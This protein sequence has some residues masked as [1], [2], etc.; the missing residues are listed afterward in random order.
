MKE[1]IDS[2]LNQTYSNWEL[3]SL[4]DCSTD[5]SPIIAE[6]YVKADSRVHYYRNEK[7]LQLP[8]NLNR[9]FSL[10]KG[11]YLTWTSDDNRYRPEALQKMADVLDKNPD[12][13]FV[14]ASSRIIDG[15][16]KEIEYIMVSP[17][18][19]DRIVGV[20][21][22]GACFLYTRLAYNTVGEYDADLKY[23]ED[24]DYWQ[25]ICMK[26][27]AIGISEILYDYR[28]HDKALTSTMS[29]EIF[30][31]NLEKMLL[32]NRPGFGKLS[33]HQNYLYYKSLSGCRNDMTANPYKWRFYAAKIQNLLL[34]RLP[35]KIK[36]I[37]G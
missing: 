25:R 35:G 33:V 32:K 16:G 20:N 37:L 21:S 36:K 1:S 13:Q 9:G 28:W 2:I 11:E 29:R 24:F 10:A 18:S 8:G 12:V 15:K 23:V 19:P 22:V 14:F 34:Y 7:N 26:F 3:L 5:R 6:E 4:D 31:N 17:D 30:N 27:R